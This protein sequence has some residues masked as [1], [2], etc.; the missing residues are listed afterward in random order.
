[1]SKGKRPRTGT[2]RVRKQGGTRATSEHAL[3]VARRL[4]TANPT[5]RVE[6]DCE[7]DLQL[8]IATILAAQC[9]DERVNRVTPQLFAKY[10]RPED[11]LAVAPEE[12]EE[13]IRQTGFFRQKTRS[14]RGAMEVLISEFGGRVPSEMVGLTLLPGVGRKTANAMSFS[15]TSS[16]SPAL[17][18]TRM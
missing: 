13:D 17:L 12:L 15:G 14:I 10:P 9:T 5:T 16:A 18:S 3:T 11:Y 6:L 7:N 1:M 4:A 2:Q 8:L